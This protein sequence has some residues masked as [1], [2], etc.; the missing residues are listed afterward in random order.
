MRLYMIRLIRPDRSR[1]R[2]GTYPTASHTFILARVPGA[3]PG[4]AARRNPGWRVASVS[5]ATP[6]EEA[7]FMALPQAERDAATII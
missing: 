6:A 5:P 4:E 3:V 7:R 1:K 2:D